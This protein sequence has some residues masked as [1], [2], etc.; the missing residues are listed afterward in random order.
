MVLGGIGTV[1]GVAVAL[2]A[3]AFSVAL[4]MGMSGAKLR[5]KLGFTGTVALLHVVMPLIGLQVGLTAGRI[6][7]V[8]AAW[9]GALVL[10]LIGYDMIKKGMKTRE[11]YSFREA[12][13]RAF[14]GEPAIWQRFSGFLTVGVLGL[15]VSVDA[16]ATGFSLGTSR[17]P[18]PLTVAVMGTVAGL[19]TASGFVGGKWLGWAAGKGAQVLG[20]GIL[21]LI[22]IQMV[23]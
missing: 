20:G 17:V 1:V 6:F 7:G 10:V 16:L 2:G 9:A 4:G 23:L 3:D 21:L 12:R 11:S 5:F 8:W 19:M 14:T 22:A 15:S 18:I 13:Q